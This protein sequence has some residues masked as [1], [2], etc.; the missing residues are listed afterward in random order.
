MSQMT[1]YIP[2]E[3]KWLQWAHRELTVTIMVTAS[4][5]LAVTEPWLSCDLAMI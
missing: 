3:K 4:R 2:W 1:N 5:D